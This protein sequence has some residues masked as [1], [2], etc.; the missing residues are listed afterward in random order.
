M[1]GM[2]LDGSYDDNTETAPISPV[3][4]GSIISPPQTPVT[5]VIED[6]PPRS[7]INNWS[8][9][10]GATEASTLKKYS[11][12][13][14]AQDPDVLPSSAPRASE[15]LTPTKDSRPSLA[16][17]NEKLPPDSMV[18]TVGD[19][20]L[21]ACSGRYAS[22]PFDDS[23]EQEIKHPC[24]IRLNPTTELGATIAAA[25][26]GVQPIPEAT[27]LA[28]DMPQTHTSGPE[29]H[30]ADMTQYAEPEKRC[31]SPSIVKEGVP[32]EG[33]SESRVSLRAAEL[34]I[35]TSTTPISASRPFAT[36]KSKET[37]ATMIPSANTSNLEAPERDYT[38][39]PICL[40]KPQGVNPIVRTGDMVDKTSS[41]GV[42]IEPTSKETRDDD[43]C[44]FILVRSKRPSPPAVPVMPKAQHCL[45]QHR[46]IE[47]LLSLF[48]IAY[49]KVP[50]ISHTDMELALFQ[51]ENLIAAAKFYE[52]LEIVVAPI[53]YSL[54]QGGH[55][56]FH[57]I[58]LEPIRWLNVSIDLRD[59]T[60]FQEAVIHL[61]GSFSDADNFNR[62]LFSGV[63]RNVVDLIYRKVVELDRG[64]FRVNEVLM[65]SSIYEPGIRA[66]LDG[67][68]KS[69]LDVNIAVH[70]WR[71]WFIRNLAEARTRPR[72]LEEPNIQSKLGML[73]RAISAGDNYLLENEMM[74][75]LRRF[76]LPQQESADRT[77]V[78]LQ[79]DTAA[80]DLT[81]IKAYASRMVRKICYNRS[82]LDPAEAGFTYLTCTSIYPGEF[83]WAGAPRN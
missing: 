56:L 21:E 69:S 45:T 74:D 9:A 22:T 79:W 5:D 1:K 24:T 64:I 53:H 6:A 19:R 34:D 27:V 67:A 73:Y 8:T 17:E 77:E 25:R 58:A 44:Q 46:K 51:T 55:L 54:A 65:S 29:S 43:E 62:K 11:E 37:S 70:Y 13:T 41:A 38:E 60:I 26:A 48:R 28:A 78:V 4:R 33:V 49:H 16:Q 72:H 57:S 68:N 14:L 75:S 61:V 66:R 32:N 47:T 50:I 30:S 59:K 2:G 71:E 80:D 12:W 83:P 82:M 35:D 36:T 3:D 76:Q 18:S 63:P 23:E 31:Y 42:N 7:S 39:T 40:L 15:E 10:V 52:A 20:T 81:L